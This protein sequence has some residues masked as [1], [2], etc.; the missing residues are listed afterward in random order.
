MILVVGETGILG[1]LITIL[2]LINGEDGLV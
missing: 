2:Q 1:G